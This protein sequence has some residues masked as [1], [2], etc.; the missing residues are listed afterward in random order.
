MNTSGLSFSE[1]LSQIRRA[2]DTRL[3]S[4]LEEQLGRAGAVHPDAEALVQS[5]LDLSKRG[6]K[7]LR[8]ALTW[9]GAKA[10]Y[11]GF[12]LEDVVDAGIALEL[13]QA[14]FLIHDD[15]MDG[16]AER[17]GGPTA[18]IALGQRYGSQALGDRSAILAGD[19]AIAL[20]QECLAHV[21]LSGRAITRAFRVFAEMQMAAVL[22]QQLDVVGHPDR[23]ELTYELKTASYT[24]LGP[25]E[26][27]AVLA[28]GTPE[29]EQTLRKYARPAGVAFQLRD[30]LIG[31]FGDP[32]VTG[33]PRGGDLTSGKMTP[34]L[35]EA[36]TRLPNRGRE[37]LE[38]VFGNRHAARAEVETVVELIAASGA[39]QTIDARID[40]LASEA[41][42]AL[43]SP[44]ISPLGRRLLVEAT[45]ALVTR[46]S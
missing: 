6:G 14:Y 15:W 26:L 38:G 40:Q 16:D 4:R 43:E 2:V 20:S 45:E 17:R 41:L 5:I 44:T 27:G 36:R 9:I 29:L 25:L 18:H 32:A 7:R 12:P 37:L 31:V 42:T 22:G 10:A 11:E 21:P 34:L 30:D 24:V 28:G 8:P 35:L 19:Y 23:P 33:K 46:S 13:L 39:Q 3:Q 1:L